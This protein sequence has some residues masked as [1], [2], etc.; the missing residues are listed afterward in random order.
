MNLSDVKVGATYVYYP[1]KECEDDNRH[2]PA[3]VL[4]ITKGKRVRV[5][6]VAFGGGRPVRAVGAKRLIDGQAEIA[7]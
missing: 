1:P 7:V 2:F 4:A 6:L 5:R 3:Q